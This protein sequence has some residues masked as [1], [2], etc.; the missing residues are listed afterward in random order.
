VQKDVASLDKLLQ[1]SWRFSGYRNA[2]I[3]TKIDCCIAVGVAA[4][5]RLQLLH[6]LGVS[7]DGARS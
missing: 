2:V 1:L 5:Q 7:E 6:R 4:D 3:V